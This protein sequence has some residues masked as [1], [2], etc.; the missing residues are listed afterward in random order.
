MG[1]G[2]LRSLSRVA[3][4]IGG[5]PLG[6]NGP[7]DSWE[8]HWRVLEAGR[9]LPSAKGLPATL[10]GSLAGDVPTAWRRARASPRV[11]LDDGG[12]DCGPPWPPR[13][14]RKPVES[15]SGLGAGEPVARPTAWVPRSPWE[16]SGSP[17]PV[18]ALGC[19]AS[20]G[21]P[22]RG[23]GNLGG[24][25]FVGPS[26][27]SG[28]A[29]DTPGRSPSVVEGKA[30]RSSAPWRTKMTHFLTRRQI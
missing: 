20:R 27:A 24:P 10:L 13:T 5:A 16:A 26:R 25:R 2:T 4:N 28:R 12:M 1:Q 21:N 8:T 30:A 17:L 19:M 29:F 7:T 14:R 9:Y 6:P 22:S 3:G 15:F 18:G 23:W 11:C